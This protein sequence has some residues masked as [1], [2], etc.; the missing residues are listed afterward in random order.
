MCSVFL[1]LQGDSGRD[2]AGVWRGYRVCVDCEVRGRA[3]VVC[4]ERLSIAA[5]VCVAR[6]ELMFR[7]V[8]ARPADLSPGPVI[9]ETRDS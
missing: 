6:A 5:C 4:P 1:Q 9:P 7:K 3:E 8:R 2:A